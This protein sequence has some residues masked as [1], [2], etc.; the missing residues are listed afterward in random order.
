[1]STINLTEIITTTLLPT[2][3]AV[4]H[5]GCSN[6]W[7]GPQHVIYQLANVCFL[8]SNLAPNTIHGILFLHG[9]LVVGFLLFSVW[10]FVVK[11]APDALG[12]N[13][14]FMIINAIQVVHILYRL[15]PVK[16][17]K[18]LEDLF[19]RLFKPLQVPR[20]VFKSLVHMQNVE[21][22]DLPT[23]HR[24][25]TEGDTT[26]DRLSILLNGRLE[27]KAKGD[28]LHEI[29][30]YQFI[31]S[32]TWESYKQGTNDK[33]QVTITAVDDC[34]Y[35]MWPRKN[36][37]QLMQKDDYLA[38]VLITMMGKDICQKLHSLDEKI[39]Q[40]EKPAGTRMD[41]RL[42]SLSTFV[43][44]HDVRSLS[45]SSSIGL[46]RLRR[47]RSSDPDDDDSV[48]IDMPSG[49]NSPRA[50]LSPQSSEQAAIPE[51]ENEG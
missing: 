31:D 32:A 48:F 2:T 33:Y 26:C 1:M 13:F 14:A 3:A 46:P 36:L 16:F 18:E 5:E 39:M 15:R 25:A 50:V 43:A 12:W 21:V 22:V 4:E 7:E 29:N 23:G 38:A 35:I 37:E 44:T 28:F 11:C 40:P 41:V 27:V 34:R 51:E 49:T 42:P 6:N 30:H 10:T 17:S 47:L 8:I 45:S 9:V 20:R 19:V 24:Y